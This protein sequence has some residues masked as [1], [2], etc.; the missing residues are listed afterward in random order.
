MARYQLL[1]LVCTREYES[2][3]GIAWSNGEAGRYLF[4]LCGWS[5]LGRP[6]FKCCL[7]S[8]RLE[9]TGCQYLTHGQFVAI[10]VRLGLRSVHEIL[11]ILQAI[12]TCLGVEILLFHFSLQF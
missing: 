12:D 5:R 4:E 2:L 11:S 6:A 8:V 7:L 10:L 1:L 3:I 9:N